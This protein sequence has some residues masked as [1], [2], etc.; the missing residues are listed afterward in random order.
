MRD[1]A[2]WGWLHY[3]LY[4]Y[5]A[6]YIYIYIR[7]IG[8]VLSLGLSLSLSFSQLRIKYSRHLFLFPVCFSLSVAYS[9]DFLSFGL[10]VLL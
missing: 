4:Y 10:H 5:D 6:I 3:G 7:H 8:L 2:D 1:G 9:C